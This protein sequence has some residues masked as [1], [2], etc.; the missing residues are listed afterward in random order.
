MSVEL[1]PIT[2]AIC[3]NRPSLL[4]NVIQSS[5]GLL[6]PDDRILVVMD[7]IPVAPDFG[8]LP[9]AM[10]V[11]A[12]NTNRGLAHSR[13]R[14]LKECVT[15]L[16]IFLDDD[17]VATREAVE[18]ARAAL[19]RGADVIGARI[20]ADFQSC[21][22]PWFLSA[23]QLHYLGSH[24][25]ITPVSIWG[26]FLGMDIERIR[27]LGVDFDER[28]GRTAGTLG[29]AEDTTFVRTLVSRGGQQEV[30]PGVEVR[31]LIPASRLR[32]AYL[33]RRAFWQGRSEHRRHAVR[34]GLR[35][36]WSR[37]WQAGCSTPRRATLTAL[38]GAVVVAGVVCEALADGYR[39]QHPNMSRPSGSR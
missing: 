4:P 1:V 39:R 9:P 34:G 11:I 23:G 26:G 37:N 15:R 6:G 31:H 13:N 25:P 10:T 19:S 2:L 24:S 30:L 28:L 20:T 16:V 8:I 21:R 29:S 3:S 36:E 5:I 33:L 38:F 18:C 35:K 14:V 12:N 32:L 17:I 27:L 22:P 7:G